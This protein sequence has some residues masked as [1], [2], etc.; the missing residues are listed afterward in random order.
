ELK[1][2]LAAIR[3]AAEI[4]REHPPQP[5]AIRFTEN[6]L[7]QNGRMQ[8]LVEKLLHQ[9]KLENR[10]E[11][12]FVPVEMSVL[13]QQLQEERSA[14]AAAKALNLVFEANDAV[15]AG[16]KELLAQA[17]G[18]LLDNA[19]DF[20]PA[21]GNIVLRAAEEADKIVITVSDSGAGIPDY[22]LPRIFERFYSLPRG[23]G[24]KSSG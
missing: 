14:V 1:S 7:A 13:F 15:V 23:N 19:I 24:Q 6:I 3:G 8:R 2:P 10:L 4:L 9:A 21:G 11:I 18:N 16:D 5:V 22:A 17:V 20:T 12:A